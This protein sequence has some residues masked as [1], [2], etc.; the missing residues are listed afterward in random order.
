M[1]S[2]TPCLARPVGCREP[3]P[4]QQEALPIDRAAIDRAARL[5]A[6][7]IQVTP[8][9]HA[10]TL[11]RELGC[12][13]WLK[14]ENLQFTASF[15]ERGALNRLLSLTPEERA[16][17]VVAASAGNH[18]QGLA[19]HGSRLGI[20]TTIFMPETTPFVKISRTGV[21]GADVRLEGA[22]FS[23]A[24]EAAQRFVSQTGAVFVHPFDDPWVMAGQ[25]TVALEML[26]QAT[27]LDALV[28]P[29]GG[30]GLL[31]GMAVAAR[32]ISPA[33]R[34]YGVEPEAY[35]ALASRLRGQPVTTG[36]DTVAEGLAVQ[37]VGTRPLAIAREL[38]DDVLIVSE[39]DIERAVCRLA[40]IEKTVVEG[41]GAAG[42]AAIARY[43]KLFSGQRVGTP[44]TGGNV[45]MRVL[46]SVLMR[47]LAQDGRLAR[48]RVPV[49]DRVGTLA[50][51]TET[52][53]RVGANV[54]DIEHDRVFGLQSV[55]LAT[56]SLLVE[57]R[58]EAHAR[59]VV[60]ALRASGFD[61]LQI[62]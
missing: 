59:Q 34:I 26:S 31:A 9:L 17:G 62:A 21:L 58:D 56:L 53:A 13:L 11:S 22:N 19:W 20:R 43:P 41:A 15:K 23:E 14:F 33:I 49:A 28:I 12:E 39:S 44:L 24:F 60:E 6:G 30:G 27:D 3:E 10:A 57:T 7:Q 61:P 45:D 48:I 52:V 40:D 54:I 47:G 2:T 4:G 46:A 35:C 55:R 8:C 37:D 38:V 36:G 18:A 50:R 32:S 29:V 25:G 5:I 16:R 42:L 51:L 1:S